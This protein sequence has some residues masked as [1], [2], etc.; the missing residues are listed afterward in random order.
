MKISTLTFKDY[1][2][3]SNTDKEYV[4]SNINCLKAMLKNNGLSNDRYLHS[5]S[6]AKVCKNLA[7]AHNYD[8]NKA[9]LA[10]LLHDAC[11]TKN[12][13]LS[14]SLLIKYEPDKLNYSEKV[15]HSWACKY[16][17][18][19]MLDFADFDVLNA[20]YNHTILTSKDTLSLILYIADKREPLRGI[21]DDILKVAKKDLNLAYETLETD[22]QKYL[23]SKNERFI[24][25]C[26]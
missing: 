6:V 20:I 2:Q 5:L 8:E 23:K 10:G 16:F 26:L 21:K 7:K 4:M 1:K 24:K 12:I 14:R 11:K 13:E 15:Y 18:I 9:Y 3:L 22:V 25:N 19:E 17:L